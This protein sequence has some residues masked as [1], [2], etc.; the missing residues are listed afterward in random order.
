MSRRGYWPGWQKTTKLYKSFY[1]FLSSIYG[2]NMKR[3]AYREEIT[4]DV[5]DGP[6]WPRPLY[7]MGILIMGM[8]ALFSVGCSEPDKNNVKD[9]Y[10]VQITCGSEGEGYNTM[11]I[12]DNNRNGLVDEV[13]ISESDYFGSVGG[14]EYDIHITV[15]GIDP[16]YGDM[17]K[18]STEVRSENDPHIQ[19]YQARFDGNRF[20]VPEK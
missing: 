20:S 1:L 16:E 15:K 2:D 4:D 10:R 11:I 12:M 6:N 8:A 3:P 9:P 19:G 17:G 5:M 7:K 14:R 13:V 18:R